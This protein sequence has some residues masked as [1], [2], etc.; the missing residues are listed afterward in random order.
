MYLAGGGRLFHRVSP[1]KAMEAADAAGAGG[2]AF[3]GLA[4]LLSGA[5]FLQNVLPL[6]KTGDLL[7]AGTVP[8]INAAVGL[9][10][11]A[12]FVL[13]LGE[14][15]QENEAPPAEA[16][17]QGVP[18]SL[19]PY[20]VAAWLFLIGLYGIVT[21]RR[22]I[23]V[24]VCLSVV[25]SATY[26]LILS[27]GFRKGAHAPVFADVP[28]G[29]P[30]VDPVSH[31]LVADGHR[32]RRDRHG[33]AARPGDPGP[34]KDGDTGP[35]R[36]APDARLTREADRMTQLPPLPVALP[37]LAAAVLTGGAP[38]F[39]RW[40][41]D[42]LATATAAAVTAVCLLLLRQSSA[43]PVVYWFGGWRPHGG[44]ALGIGFVVD[45][46]GSGLAALA[47]ALVTAAFLFSWRYF[48]E[49]GTLY[50]ALLLVFLAAMCGFCLSGDLFKCL[51]FSS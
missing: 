36:P 2:Y 8:L 16:R 15:I 11:A 46:L 3:V 49:V 26:V 32:R 39:R 27:V 20:A 30:A 51:S 21:S 47:G 41:A 10:V 31:A 45:P 35:G 40:I 24:I 28:P 5:A 13:L 17:R 48:S 33:P 12:G 4:A 19:L 42:G 23:P 38:V 44:V 1:K 18:M 7:S 43:A 6:G 34:Q 29:T 22:L 37:L 9:E 50:H 14:F 25:Q